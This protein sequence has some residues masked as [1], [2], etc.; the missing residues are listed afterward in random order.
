MKFLE[1]YKEQISK[2]VTDKLSRLEDS[3]MSVSLSVKEKLLP[4]TLSGK[5]VRGSLICAV[6]DLYEG[7]QS[8]VALE[9]AASTELMQSMILIIDDMIDQDTMRRGLTTIHKQFEKDLK[10]EH[11]GKSMAMC[12]A[13]ISGF[14]AVG[15]LQNHPKEVIDLIS[16][17]LTFVGYGEMQ[18]LIYSLGTQPSV[19]QVLAVYKYKTASYTFSLPMS[20][21][22][23][24]A[25]APKEEVEKIFKLGEHLGLLFQIRDDM[26]EE[27]DPSITGKSK[28]DE[29]NN[30]QTILSLLGEE[31]TQEMIEEQKTLAKDIIATMKIQEPFLQIID[32]IMTRTK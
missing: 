1:K 5:M 21:G 13:L 32:Y 27:L 15:L 23:I 24:L 6:H 16:H 18:E 26:L 29:D 4:F 9:S 30:T 22:A 2:L 10:D 19:E 31:K 8:Q 3:Q 17:Q 11:H 7:E 12:L 25:K 14:Q 20:T 28:S